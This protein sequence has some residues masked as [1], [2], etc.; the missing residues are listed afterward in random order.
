MKKRVLFLCIG[1]ICRSP[2]A[3]AL[4]RKYGSD[5][6]EVSSAGLTPQMA[7]HAY[8]RS[9]LKEKNVELGDHLPRGF[10]DLDLSQYD[11]IV[12]MSGAT[13]PSSIDVPV[14]NWDIEDPYGGSE[15]DFRAAREVIEMAV[16]RL[17]LRVRL[18][19]L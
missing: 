5:V 13:L 3:E 1:N 4:A 17:I 7:S 11:L 19:K 6:L 15:D 9:V 8:T 18:G 16:M 10:R 12:N 2:M 14:E